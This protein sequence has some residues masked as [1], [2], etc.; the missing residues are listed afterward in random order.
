MKIS[1][2][3]CFQTEGLVEIARLEETYQR[4]LLSIEEDTHE[5]GA[6]AVPT[7]NEPEEDLGGIELEEERAEAKQPLADNQP[8]YYV[9]IFPAG[10]QEV[11]AEAVAE[12][13]LLSEDSDLEV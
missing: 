1:I 11:D 13:L 4:A 9:E 12:A 5:N 8:S 7:E 3:N 2:A 6:V 10:E